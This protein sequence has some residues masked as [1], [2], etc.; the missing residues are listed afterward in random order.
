MNQDLRQ[1]LSQS[2]NGVD[3]F[4]K[5]K[6]LEQIEVI[7]TATPHV[8][9]E[10][11]SGLMEQEQINIIEHLDPND[12]TDILQRLPNSL[13][14]GLLEKIDSNIKKELSA[15]LKFEPDT[16]AG[17]MSLDYV[18]VEADMTMTEISEKVKVHEQRTGRV[19]TVIVLDDGK[20]IGHLPIW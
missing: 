18:Q 8:Q 5:L 11:F 6:T 20:L 19:P 3:A 14:D 15:L 17:I 10:L 12:A 16:A 9:K 13:R 4:R 1:I 2:K 7:S